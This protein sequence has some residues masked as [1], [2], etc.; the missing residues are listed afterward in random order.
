MSTKPSSNT[1]QAVPVIGVSVNLPETSSRDYQN[2][3]PIHM[4]SRR[5]VAADKQATGLEESRGLFTIPE[6]EGDDNS[7]ND[8]VRG[9]NYR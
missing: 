6:D 8:I 2:M 9:D 3:Q 1:Q 4:E 7:S 5:L